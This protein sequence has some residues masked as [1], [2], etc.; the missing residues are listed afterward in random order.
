M[1]SISYKDKIMNKNI[2]QFFGEEESDSYSEIVD[3]T[4]KDF[5]GD[6]ELEQYL[7]E[8]EEDDFL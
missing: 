1:K 7:S 2:Q 5:L 8:E 3:K 4:H 6:Y